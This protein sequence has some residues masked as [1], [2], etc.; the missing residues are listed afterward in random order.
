M[1]HVPKDWGMEIWLVNNEVYCA[2]WLFVEPGWQCSLHRHQ[3]KDETF[4]VESGLCR[5]EIE[6]DVKLLKVGDSARIYP[7][8][9]HRFANERYSPMCKILEV[10]SHHSDEDVERREASR[11]ID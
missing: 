2:K 3:V 5:I 6:N 4:I 10:S 1:K 9:W 7:G 11:R 8:Q